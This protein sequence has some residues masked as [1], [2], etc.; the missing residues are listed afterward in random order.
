MRPQDPRA[1][2]ERRDTSVPD[3]L[4]LA[5]MPPAGAA[6]GAGP[7][8]WLRPSRS[9]GTVASGASL[10]VALLVAIARSGSG[11]GG[12]TADSFIAPP[13]YVTPSGGAPASVPGPSLFG[14]PAL[15]LVLSGGS[16]AAALAAHR[17]LRRARASGEAER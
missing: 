4:A 17:G 5:E 12:W 3:A 7:L 14:E 13:E 16:A 2:S 11:L 15:W 6:P 1:S 10:F 8:N 9:L